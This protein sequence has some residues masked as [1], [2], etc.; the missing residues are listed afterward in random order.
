[1]DAGEMPGGS[2]AGALYEVSLETHERRG[3]RRLRTLAWVA[4][5]TLTMG[6]FG[7]PSVGELVV[8]RRS[9]RAEV[10]RTDA[11]AE[12]SAAQLLEHV[13]EQLRRLSPVEFRERWGIVDELADPAG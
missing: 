12:E 1:M 7:F 2:R 13:H 6:F 4:A 11:E 8:R 9:D 10:L 5:S 3:L